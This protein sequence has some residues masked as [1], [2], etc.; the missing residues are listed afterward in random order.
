MLFPWGV[1]IGPQFD[2]DAGVILMSWHHDR[3]SST[4]LAFA[5][6]FC[7]WL[8]SSE[9]LRGSSYGAGSWLLGV[10][11]LQGVV[12]HVVAVRKS[13]CMEGE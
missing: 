7:G 11:L 5:T 13:P 6:P 12:V 9:P 10:Q 4:H 8:A 1:T 2:G 3:P